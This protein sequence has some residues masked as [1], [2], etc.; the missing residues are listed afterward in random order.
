MLIVLFYIASIG[1]TIGRQNRT[2][3]RIRRGR[4]TRS[5]SQDLLS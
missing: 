1:D 5:E 2:F 3:H 4:S